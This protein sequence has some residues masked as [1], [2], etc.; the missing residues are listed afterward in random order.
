MLAPE[1]ELFPANALEPNAVLVEI[2]FFPRPTVIEF[3]VISP[4]FTI[5]LPAVPVPVVP[6]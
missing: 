5:T 6:G 3:T 2:L 4:P 1:P